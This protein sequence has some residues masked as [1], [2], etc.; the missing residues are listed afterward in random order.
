MTMMCRNRDNGEDFG[1][2]AA[3]SKEEEEWHSDFDVFDSTIHEVFVI[4][5]VTYL[6]ISAVVLF[7]A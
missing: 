4:E 3:T 2:R 7:L 5:F 6:A 1:R